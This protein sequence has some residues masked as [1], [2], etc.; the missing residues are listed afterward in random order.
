MTLSNGWKITSFTLYKGKT[1]DDKI[2]KITSPI[3]LDL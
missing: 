1:E 2:G 3:P